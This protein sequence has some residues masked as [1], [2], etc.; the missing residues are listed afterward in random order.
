MRRFPCFVFP[1]KTC[2]YVC[3]MFKPRYRV[4]FIWRLNHLLLL[5]IYHIIYIM[6]VHY[7]RI[8]II[9]NRKNVGTVSS[10]FSGSQKGGIVTKGQRQVGKTGTN[11]LHV[12]YVYVYRTHTR[13]TYYYIVFVQLIYL[14]IPL[15]LFCKT[16]SLGGEY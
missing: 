13:R 16:I 9:R 15:R 14:Q 6:Y 7:T 1:T 8:R 12:S 10:Q 2:V 3:V 11:N 4:F 5:F